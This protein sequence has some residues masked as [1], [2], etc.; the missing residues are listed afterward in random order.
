MSLNGL[1]QFLV[2]SSGQP[3][4]SGTTI[5]STV[6]N[7]LTADLATAL[8]T[9]VYKDGQQT[10]TANIP[11]SAFKA[12][13]LGVATILGDAL[14]FGNAATVAALTA[15]GLTDI[16]GAAAGQIKFPATQNPSAN[17]NTLDDYE[18]NTWTPADNS[19]A[20]LVFTSVS[21]SYIKI[22]QLVYI[23]GQ[24]TYPV[25]AN[26]GGAA[27]TLPFTSAAIPR[28]FI[29]CGL[30]TG[31]VPILDI[32]VGN[33][34]SMALRNITDVPITNATMSGSQIAFSGCYQAIA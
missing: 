30:S 16:S 23:A 19:G 21:G 17:A 15:T 33:P 11:F 22:G 28:Q 27:I 1:G 6:F 31:S 12:T 14:S 18:E 9:A 10:M 2:N 20:S 4:V 3:V 26:A 8:S 13:G 5:S 29:T 24:L 32:T 25:T 7:S 34:T